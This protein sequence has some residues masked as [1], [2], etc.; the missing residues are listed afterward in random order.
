MKLSKLYSNY[1]DKFGPINFNKGLNV[2]IGEIK[3][4]NR[5]KDTHNLGKSTFMKVIDFC[6]L[7]KKEKDFFLFKH[8]D[9]FKDFIFFI[10]IELIDG[11]YVTVR[12]SVADASKISLK[13]HTERHQDF[14]LSTDKDWDHHNIKLERSKHILEGLLNLQVLKSF[15]YRNALAYFL[16]PQN[17]Y[18]NVFK[19]GKYSISK[20]VDWKPLMANILGFNSDS[21]SE[22]YKKEDER[23]GKQDKKKKLENKVGDY[24]NKIENLEKD[25]K[26]KDDNIKKIDD[27]I[28]RFDFKI[29]DEEKTK[30]LAGDIDIRMSILN[31]ERYSLEHNK[32]KIANI[33]AKQ[34]ISFDTKKASA[35]FKDVGLLFE[36][37]IKKS[38]DELIAFN[39]AI[40]EERIVYLK[41]ELNELE[42]EVSEINAQINELTQKRSEMLAFI[43]SDKVFDKYKQLSN[44]L[45]NIKIEAA[46]LVKRRELVVDINKLKKYIEELTKTIEEIKKNIVIDLN[47]S[48]ADQ[49]SAFSSIN[50]LFAGIIKDVIGVRSWLDVSI[51]DAGHLEFNVNI[52]D[53]NDNVT[54]QGDG[55]T[56]KKFQ[57]IAFNLSVLRHYI[58]SK[59]IRFAYHDGIFEGLD[60]RKKQNLLGIIEK[61]TNSGIQLIITLIDSDSPPPPEDSK[62]VFNDSDIILKLHDNGDEGRLFRMPEW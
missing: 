23:K 47:N 58:D 16:R 52:A 17:D 27:Q 56:Y 24:L 46:L 28:N 41:K 43:G 11:T 31:N 48:K 59:F 44:E 1:P 20:D 13:K 45:V 57:C 7:S 51:N 37:Q 19:S 14:L 49:N 60:D 40:T 53:D 18:N 33:C 2:I 42:S 38:F 50:S 15:K 34:E 36:G 10:E 29:Q 61:C 30:L 5:D 22:Q 9:I 8:Y 26:D 4:E 55:N 25:I 32:K 35:L 6:L 39:K 3:E 54:S 62:Q 21:I 12:R